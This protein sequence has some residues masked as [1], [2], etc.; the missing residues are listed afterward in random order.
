MKHRRDYRDQTQPSI[1]KEEIDAYRAIRALVNELVEFLTLTSEGDG[2]H[3]LTV[4]VSWL[5]LMVSQTTAEAVDS[6]LN[7]GGVSV[8]PLVRTKELD[9]EVVILCG[10]VD[11]EFPAIFR[12]DAFLHAK[13]RRTESDRLREDRF[14]FYQ[15]LKCFRRHLY[16]IVPAHDGE[17]ELVQSTFVDELRR[18]AEIEELE[19]DNTTLF[20]TE[21]FLKHYGKFV[22]E[23][24]EDREAPSLPSAIAPALRLI[25]HNVR[26]EKSRTVTHELPH[27]EGWLTHDLLSPSSRRA[28]EERRQT[29]HSVSWL[30][31]YGQCPFQ[32]FSHRLLSL[33]RIE[34]EEEEGLTEREKGNRLHKILFEFY[35]RRRD[36]PPISA[37][38][39]SEFET[40]VQELKQIAQKHLGQAHRGGL[41]WE[42][43]METLIGGH[44]R[45]GVLPAF[46]EAERARKLEAQP[47]YFEVEFGLS[48]GKEWTDARLGSDLPIPVGDVSLSGRIDRIEMGNGFFIVGDYKT[49]SVHPKIGDIL[50]GRSLQLP[51]Y[52][53]VVEQ[54]MKR[55]HV[56]E[57]RG[58]GGVYYVLREGGKADLGIGEQAYN[59]RGFK[60]SSRNGQL[61]GNVQEIINLSVEYVNRYVR[62]I[63]SGEFPLTSHDTQLVCRSC[64]FK[65]ICRVGVIGE[66]DQ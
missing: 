35:D 50:E 6:A 23:Q 28:L 59:G 25:A 26:V 4:Y 46:L 53:T 39:D 20:S 2:R 54:L 61:V 36:G 12:S 13:R 37:Y 29:V 49:G 34:E 9:F 5:R 60:A 64:S 8:L 11:G 7:T 27:Y 32:Y 30:E 56:G 40:A 21:R 16:L 18:V 22:W 51:I 57:V 31:S 3:P 38:T 10:L 48:G 47:R 66:E 24:S 41:F 44:G 63:S 45:K 58:I 19:D 14:L 65:K 62:S 33:N 17:I 15:A 42:I 52:L 1:I 43:E 55:H